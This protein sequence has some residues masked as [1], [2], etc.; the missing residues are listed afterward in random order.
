MFHVERLSVGHARV[1]L[2]VEDAD[3]QVD[4]ARRMVAEGWNV[5]QAE[6]FVAQINKPS[7]A[8]KAKAP[9]EDRRQG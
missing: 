8:R 4:L 6:R 9:P 3:R 7:Q 1:L 5:R 2:G